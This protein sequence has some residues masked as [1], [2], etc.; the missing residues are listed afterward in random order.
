[1]EE[2]EVVFRGVTFA[3]KGEE[4][5]QVRTILTER[6]SEI[7]GAAEGEAMERKSSKRSRLYGP[8]QI[9]LSLDKDKTDEDIRKELEALLCERRRSQS[10]P[11]V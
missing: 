11:S 6:Q 3:L 10:R 9:V 8:H 4:A 7:E 2:E 1:M 5:Q